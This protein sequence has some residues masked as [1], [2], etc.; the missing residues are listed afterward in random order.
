MDTINAAL[1]NKNALLKEIVAKNYKAAE[2]FEKYGIDFCCNGNRPLDQACTEKNV[3]VEEILNK[4]DALNNTPAPP[5][6]YE[7]WTLSYLID[8]I[9]N[10]HHNYIQDMVP[11]IKEHLNKVTGKHS[12][13]HN[14]LVRINELF[15]DL[16][17][18]L[19]LHLKKEER[20]LFPLIKELEFVVKANPG[21]PADLR[22]NIKGPISMMEMEHANAGAIFEEMKK[23][24]DNFT[25]PDD[26]CA[27]YNLTYRELEEFE[28]DLHKHIF[29]ENSILFPK[30][31]IMSE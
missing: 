3:S 17:N 4:L 25:T 31:I 21:R 12:A 30:A 15:T 1:D 24:S 14:E 27:T 23:L 20:I 2:I 19:L 29:L 7:L 10:N 5:E 16:S 9:I 6:K 26:G 28:K 13:R 22:M 18:E 11:I 8:H